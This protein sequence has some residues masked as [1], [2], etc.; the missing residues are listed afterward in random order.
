MARG[1][2]K[3][4]NRFEAFQEERR[5]SIIAGLDAALTLAKSTMLRFDSIT[6]ISCYAASIIN[7]RGQG[8]VS[9][10]TLR[11]NPRYRIQLEDFLAR[12]DR[13]STISEGTQRV[14]YELEISELKVKIKALE[15]F[16]AKNLEPQLSPKSGAINSSANSAILKLCQLIEQL[17]LASEG[18]LALEGSEIIRPYAISKAMRVVADQSLVSIYLESQTSTHSSRIK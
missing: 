10:A 16:I 4:I 7:S 18:I 14:R 9:A 13:N 12:N 15:N 8:P 2:Q 1:A 5:S 3:G 17:L 11:K 6:P